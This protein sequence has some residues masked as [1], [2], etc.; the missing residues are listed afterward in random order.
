MPSSVVSNCTHSSSISVILSLFF[1][2]IIS[3]VTSVPAFFL[4]VSSG[5]RIAPIS[6][7]LCEIYLLTLSS[8]LS[9]VPLL[10]INAITPFGLILSNV[11]AKK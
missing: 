1:K 6:S 2:N 10:V 9:N 11:F 8:F 7:A 5:N 3:V 4:K